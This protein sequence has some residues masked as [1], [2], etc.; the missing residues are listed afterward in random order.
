MINYGI[1]ILQ[2]C[3]GNMQMSTLSD[4]AMTSLRFIT[5]KKNLVT[6]WKS[7]RFSQYVEKNNVE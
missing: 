1:V 6:Y 2:Q 4:I 5:L 3:H 7:A